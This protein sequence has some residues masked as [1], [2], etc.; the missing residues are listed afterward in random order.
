MVAL[1]AA[2]LLVPPWVD[3]DV[4]T[5]RALDALERACDAWARAESAPIGLTEAVF[6]GRR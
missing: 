3:E 2:G 5:G 4:P 1:A 6:E